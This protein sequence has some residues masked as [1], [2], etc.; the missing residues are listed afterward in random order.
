ML[1]R[2]TL[3]ARRA[4]SSG[5]GAPPKR[6]KSL[7]LGYTRFGQRYDG[8]VER[9]LSASLSSPRYGAPVEGADYDDDVDFSTAPK[10]PY[11]R[12]PVKTKAMPTQRPMRRARSQSQYE[13]PCIGFEV[14]WFSTLYILL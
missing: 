13:A 9:K 6:E 1:T 14:G 11:K 4:L 2:F 3:G 8:G 5:K 7:G 12:P 10:V